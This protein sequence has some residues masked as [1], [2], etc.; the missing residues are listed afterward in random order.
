MLLNLIKSGLD[1]KENAH[2]TILPEI[3]PVLL[4]N[5]LPLVKLNLSVTVLHDIINS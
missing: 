5:G 2:Y 3:R 1:G 4:V